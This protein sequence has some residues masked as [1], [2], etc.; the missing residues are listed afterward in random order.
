MGGSQATHSLYGKTGHPWEGLSLSGQRG[1]RSQS[2]K[3]RENKKIMTADVSG[4]CLGLLAQKG[5]DLGQ[6][7][8]LKVGYG[9]GELLGGG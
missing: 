6:P 8:Y 9:S 1:L 2:I 5:W 7:E 3:N 4:F